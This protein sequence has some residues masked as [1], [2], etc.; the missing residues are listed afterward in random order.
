MYF[1]RISQPLL[2]GRLM[3]FY[4]PNQT[5]MTIREAYTYA[6]CIV[7]SSFFYVMVSHSQ[8]LSLQHLGMKIRIACCS[9]IYRKTLKLSKKALGKTTIGQM[10]NL[11]SND[12]NR[13]DNCF[14]QFHQLWAAP[15]E[16]I[17]VMYLL[18]KLVGLTS[19]S[20]YSLLLFFIPLQS[21]YKYLN[22]NKLFHT[23]SYTGGVL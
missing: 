7:L 9:L 3:D 18:F 21:K 17:V 19:L 4:V 12:V 15:L 16:S 6:T 20:G 2:L 22:Q 13:F 1:S 10:I 8:I 14:K 5:S 11:L 23:S